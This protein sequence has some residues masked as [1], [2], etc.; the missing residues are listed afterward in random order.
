MKTKS[1]SLYGENFLPSVVSYLILLTGIWFLNWSSGDLLSYIFM[2]M[3]IVGFAMAI[4]VLFSGKPLRPD[5]GMIQRILSNLFLTWMFSIAYAVMLVV[6]VVFILGSYTQEWGNMDP[7]AYGLMFWALVMAYGA[8]LLFNYFGSKQYL[9]TSGFNLLFRT[10]FRTLPFVVICVFLV[11]KLMDWFP[12]NNAALLTGIIAVRM[13][14]DY[15]AFWLSKT[16]G[17]NLYIA[18]T[19]NLNEKRAGK[20]SDL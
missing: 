18:A 15:I 14:L 1:L 12:G 7:A 9:H 3:V 2:E 11:T 13:A 16:L 4:R 20:Q 10:I 17:F 6:F 8:D 5:G 19:E